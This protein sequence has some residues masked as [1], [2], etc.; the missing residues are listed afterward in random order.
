[1]HFCDDFLQAIYFQIKYAKKSWKKFEVASISVFNYAC[2]ILLNKY[3]C[4]YYL[5]H[6]NHSE[7][8]P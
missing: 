1:M 5:L 3:T 6:I 7:I 4:I 8:K 2:F